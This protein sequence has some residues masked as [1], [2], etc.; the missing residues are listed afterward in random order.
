[1]PLSSVES[2]LSHDVL[3]S[4]MGN[5]L[6][7]SN[8]L[9]IPTVKF[10]HVTK[11]QA[12]RCQQAQPGCDLF[13]KV[14]EGICCF[15]RTRP[16]CQGQHQGQAGA[17]SR[18]CARARLAP[19]RL[20]SLAPQPASSQILF[21]FT[22]LRFFLIKYYFIFGYLTWCSRTIEFIFI[23]V[24]NNTEGWCILNIISNIPQPTP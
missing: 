22:S 2:L 5:E 15:G 21:H 1:M 13:E 17:A 7:P 12:L 3:T 20:P 11:S 6:S 14:Q 4:Q 23:P 19:P 16:R 24:E 9:I 10:R 8:E 18:V